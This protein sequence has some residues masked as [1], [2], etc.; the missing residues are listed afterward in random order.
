MKEK[1]T[2]TIE[3]V[4]KELNVSRPTAYKICN[5]KGFPILAIGRRKV[6][7]VEGFKKWIRENTN[8]G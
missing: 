5:S 8:E 6:V 3:E 7:P 1:F 4:G 2:M